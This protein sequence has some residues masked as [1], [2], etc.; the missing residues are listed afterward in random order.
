MAFSD[1]II[2]L[3]ACPKDNCTGIYVG[4]SA[5]NYDATDNPG[6]WD[7]VA[8]GTP[9]DVTGAT[10]EI[11]DPSGTVTEVDVTTDFNQLPAIFAEAIDLGTHEVYTTDG[12]YNIKLT[13]TDGDVTNIY[14]LCVFTTCKVSCCVDKLWGDYAAK[15]AGASDC[16]C[17][18]SEVRDKALSA[19]A[20]LQA[21]KSTAACNNPTTRNSLLTKLQRICNAEECNC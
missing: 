16:G 19:Q 1:I 6:G 3:E 18:E 14:Y 21:I 17:N 8:T 13:I 11:T 2:T 9:Q 4:A 7:S 15:V 20:L 5:G 10:L 12:E